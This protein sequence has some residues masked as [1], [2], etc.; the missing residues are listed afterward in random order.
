MPALLEIYAQEKQKDSVYYYLS[1]G[2]KLRA[3]LP[4]ESINVLGFLHARLNFLFSEG[5][6]AQVLEQMLAMK[7]NQTISA[8]ASFYQRLATCC[9]QLGQYPQAYHYMDSAR[10]VTDSLAQVQLTQR[11]AELN[12]KY[13]TQSKE[14]EISLL[15]QEQLEKESWWM[16]ASIAAIS[17]MALLT[18][19]FLMMGYKLKLALIHL[20]QLRKKS[21]LAEARK[22]IEGL[23]NERKRWAKELHDGLANDLL[24]LEFLLGSCPPNEQLTS[25]QRQIQ[26]LR[27]NVREISHDLMP[28]EFTHLSLDEI[29]HHYTKDLAKQSGKQIDFAADPDTDWKELSHDV[30]Y[31]VY[32]IVQESMANILKHSPTSVIEISLQRHSTPIAE[33]KIAYPGESIQ[34]PTTHTPGGIGLLTMHDRAR[35]IEGKLS[36]HHTDGKN[37]CQL[38]FPFPNPTVLS[39]K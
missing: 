19:G 29:L 33:L 18:V 37:V 27:K 34:L 14:F 8:N 36:F 30:A 5:A 38:T 2:E 9:Y 15:K 7:H 6:Y 20:E 23:E 26:N 12:V 22:Y 25:I 21:E 16:K 3:S 35:A 28:P 31:E 39:P 13:E 10:I 32:R 17:L 24:G 11:M 1:L 4:D